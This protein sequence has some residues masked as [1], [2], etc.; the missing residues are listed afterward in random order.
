M[1]ILI[2]I[3]HPAHVHYFKNLARILKSK[4]HEIF[5]TVKSLRSAE[6]L[7]ERNGFEYIELPKKLDSLTGKAFGQFRYDWYL[8]RLCK[9][10]KIDLTLGVSV[11]ITHL[12]KIAGIR[13][14]VFDDDD[15]DV[16]PL[17]VKWAQPFA[18]ELSFP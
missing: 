17:F 11:T 14:I 3:G 15:D 18:T 10:L 16:Q 4:G 13:S 8:M 1:R 12:T 2:D 9:K 5:I 6:E 7:L